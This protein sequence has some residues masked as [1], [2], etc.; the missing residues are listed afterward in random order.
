MYESVDMHMHALKSALLHCGLEGESLQTL[1]E[2]FGEISETINA[3]LSAPVRVLKSTLLKQEIHH[4][5]NNSTTHLMV[6]QIPENNFIKKLSMIL[7]PDLI[8]T[9]KKPR[10]R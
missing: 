5:L 4:Q 6:L 7:Q 2:G 1:R 3:K 10:K 8:G 9:P